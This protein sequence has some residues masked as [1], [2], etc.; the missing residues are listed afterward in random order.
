MN[1]ETLTNDANPEEDE[2]VVIGFGNQAFLRSTMLGHLWLWA[3]I[4]AQHIQRIYEPQNVGSCNFDRYDWCNFN[5]GTED[6]F[7]WQ[8]DKT[9]E[10]SGF[11][12][13]DTNVHEQGQ[14][15]R[16]FTPAINFKDTH[17]VT[18][19]FKIT[20]H[21]ELSVYVIRDF[22][23]YSQPVWSSQSITTE[24]TTVQLAL[25]PQTYKLVFEGQ[26][27][28][29]SNGFIALDNI[30]VQYRSCAISP[31]FLRLGD[32]VVNEGQSAELQCIA[33]GDASWG[34]NIRLQKFSS[35]MEEKIFRSHNMVNYQSAKFTWPAIGSTDADNIRCVASNATAAGVSN[36][37]KLEVRRPPVP[38][39]APEVE[40]A[41]PTHLIVRL[42]VN[43]NDPG[44]YTGDGPVTNVEFR[45]KKVE[46]AWEDGHDVDLDSYNGTY[47]IWHLEP[48]T[49]YMLCVV[50][51]R[52]GPGGTG[53]PGPCLEVRTKCAKPIP[54]TK[55]T[56]S[57][58]KG[59]VA[60]DTAESNYADNLIVRW[61]APSPRHA[62]CRTWGYVLRWRQVGGLW[63]TKE[64][65]SNR[66]IISNLRS[67]TPYEVQV[68]IRNMVGSTDSLIVRT[69]TNDGF[70]EAI[71][72]Y[73]INVITTEDAIIVQWP[74]PA[75]PN[76]E[77]QSYKLEYN[78]FDAFEPPREVHSGPPFSGNFNIPGHKNVYTIENLPPGTIY[79]LTL[80]SKTSAGYG[81]PS[82]FLGTT[83]IGSPKWV[84]AYDAVEFS[85]T[86]DI[87]VK[88]KGAEG[89]GAPVSHYNVV[90][91]DVGKTTAKRARR[92]LNRDR[93][94]DRAVHYDTYREKGGSYYFAAE[95]D[96][97][98]FEER[99]MEFP[100]RVGDNN[101]YK[102]FRNAP[103]PP[104]AKVQVWVQAVSLQ[105]G[106]KLSNC[107]RNVKCQVIATRGVRAPPPPEDDEDE[108]PMVGTT[109]AGS[110]QAGLGAQSILLYGGV[111]V[112][113]LLLLFVF[114]G[115]VVCFRRRALAMGPE[116]YRVQSPAD[117]GNRTDG[118]YSDSETKKA[119]SSYPTEKTQLMPD[120]VDYPSSS[121]KSEA[122]DFAVRVEDFPIHVSQM[123]SSRTY[124]FADEFET[125]PEGSTASWIVA[126]KP[127]NIQKNRY[128][129]ILPYDH[130][131][132]ILRS[133]SQIVQTGDYINAS[134]ISGYGLRYIAAQ[135]PTEATISDFW[136]CIWQENIRLLIMV[137]GLVEVGR[138]KCH[139]YWPNDIRGIEKF[140]NF[141][142]ELMSEQVLAHYALREIKIRLGSYEP[143]IVR[144]M[145][146][147]S[148]P[149]HGVPTRPT[150]LLHFVRR[151]AQL[152]PDNYP[153][154]VHCSAGSGRS[155][156]FIVLDWMLRMADSEGLL[157]IFNTVKELRNK[158]VNMVANLEQ[159]IFLH[160]SLLEA[161][162]CGETG[163]ASLDLNSH[164]DNLITVTG[165]AAPI[166]EEFE[167]L[168]VL[169]PRLTTEECQTARLA[170]NR[171]KNR[172]Q[173]VLPADRDL[174]YLITPDPAG[175]D[176]SHNYIN[177][178]FADSFIVKRDLI[179]TQM[180]LP[181][182]VGDFWRLVHDYNVS[183][184]VMLNDSTETDETCANYWPKDQTS[185]TYSAFTVECENKDDEIE[186]VSR[187]LKLTNYYRS[188]D[189]AKVVKLLQLSNWPSGQPVPSSRNAVL[190][191]V[192]LIDQHRSN[193][194]PGSRV[195]LHCVAG[196][197]K[198]GTFAS[199]YNV[200]QQLRTLQS[201]DVFSSVLQ[202]RAVRPQLVET[203]EQ[204]RFIYEVAMEFAD[205]QE[206]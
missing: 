115:S 37:A 120:L 84:A 182:T 194:A 22:F 197:G 87:V 107:D 142:V 134:W 8:M 130:S 136:H 159:Y 184:V 189:P 47:R 126:T 98:I 187:N 53:K 161:V 203:L 11:A 172:F 117:F 2:P 43:L 94:F 3:L 191:L 79:N 72:P 198:S 80:S 163:V 206:M 81:R 205:S 144:Q 89:N 57:P 76:G 13:I 177:A 114:V 173:D 169:T 204:Y 188:S 116:R 186:L 52:P 70:P 137:T 165:G 129:N 88:L 151:S 34:Q 170:R 21:G 58:Y 180:P 183:V 82:E 158:R 99:G 96:Q 121:R 164:Y 49:L 171:V 103:I 1:R 25:S 4:S 23:I 200:I 74:Y 143:R 181:H 112:A 24:W 71:P 128:T 95:I 7:D 145:Q 166:Q 12:F 178:V 157:D 100:F 32:L 68:A 27:L 29:M 175:S 92:S 176:P 135:G 69:K 39:R 16:L 45:Y 104:G 122:E 5:H 75:M 131:R 56:V 40:S 141:S 162:L 86:D 152:N 168:A 51:E 62:G 54:L 44:S 132:V 124:S 63:R 192:S 38:I 20:G 42:N 48:D 118:M 167:T 85:T 190:R 147:Q 78:F 133:N 201:A 46:S 110:L 123:R 66:T 138:R 77:I 6:E 127:E 153:V 148:W 17:C 105:P 61:A 19:D 154:L 125:L 101:T 102:T 73:S 83:K 36:Y 50:L 67:D 156:C 196:A 146:F 10:R 119:P 97:T 26:I 179:I 35:G 195:L 113:L 149:D 155:G 185:E 106:C 9:D 18:F 65:Q 41:G 31:H 109:A 30:D 59:Q 108:E 93:C 28:S 90:V 202:L 199:C 150:G 140:G 139:Q 55:I 33:N 174:P 60:S 15:S 64:P 14:H 160:E 91:Q 193:L 111:S